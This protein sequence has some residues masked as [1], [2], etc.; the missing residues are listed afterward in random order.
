MSDNLTAL[1]TEEHRQTYRIY[2][3]GRDLP[4]QITG[5]L[6]GQAVTR[7]DFP[8]VGDYVE[9]SLHALV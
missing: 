8:V 1:V 3:D 7:L 4:A 6:M 9:V 5:K 2:L